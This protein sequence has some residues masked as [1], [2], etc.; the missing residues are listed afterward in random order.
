MHDDFARVMVDGLLDELPPNAIVVASSDY[1]VGP[2]LHVFEAENRRSDVVF[3]PWG[4]AG[5]RWYWEHLQAK[6]PDLERFELRGP[7]GPLGRLVR[8]VE[9]NPNRQVVGEVRDDLLMELGQRICGIGWGAHLH[10]GGAEGC[11][12]ISR[13]SPDAP[14]RQAYDRLGNGAPPVR[15]VA[16]AY[17]LERGLVLWRLGHPRDAYEALLGG[18]P[19]EERVISLPA[20]VRVRALRGPLMQWERHVPYGEPA[21]NHHVMAEMLRNAGLEEE[22]AR[23]QTLCGDLPEAQT[24]T[25]SE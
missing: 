11:A 18:V 25:R 4:F 2:L 15:G 9:A 22:A 6:H 17:G 12:D 23:A 14:L 13:S 24:Q 8:L 1:W 5:S 3:I 19:A 16:A 20:D 21:R 10:L 7:G